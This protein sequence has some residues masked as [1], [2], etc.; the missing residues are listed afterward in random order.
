MTEP[1]T[2][3][4]RRMPGAVLILAAM[5][6]LHTGSALTTE[7][8]DDV[9]PAGTT[10]LRVGFAAVLLLAFTGR[11]LWPAL[12]AAPRRDLVAVVLLGTVSGA[13]MLLFSEAADRIPL[14]T[15]T[16]LE[17]LGPLAVAVASLR[18]RRELA[19]LLL[20]A[21][22]VLCLTSPWQDGADLAG[23]LFGV[24]SGACWALYVIGTQHVGS[25]FSAAHGL[26]VSL[27]VAAV[28]TAP[29]GAPGVVSGGTWQVVLAV[30]GIAV[31][32]PLVPFLLEMKALQRVG[33]TAYGTLAGM[34][35]AVSL[36]AA[37]VLVSQVPTA[38]QAVGTALVVVAGVG[39]ARAER[40]VLPVPPARPE[41]SLAVPPPAL[42]IAS[43][44][45]DRQTAP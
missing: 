14:G 16:A 42:P 23:V 22:G 11:S 19:W 44:V 3:A 5:T 10:W 31:L 29:F 43:A 39:A 27:T 9:G 6:V 34:E 20:A 25:R 38:L 28:F 26:A 8:F 41:P 13:M 32:M 17:F 18:R 21:A 1:H 24:A 4:S 35:P 33:R 15:A 36:L 2:F 30:A 37:L 7:L 40:D 45:S 12:R